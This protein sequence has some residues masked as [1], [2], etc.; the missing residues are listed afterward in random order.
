MNYK[1]KY[2]TSTAS[3]KSTL[4]FLYLIFGRD[5]LLFSNFPTTFML[6]RR[7]LQ[8]CGFQNASKWLIGS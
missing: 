7:G 1:L 8:I 2:L 6:S 3:R 5:M 4:L